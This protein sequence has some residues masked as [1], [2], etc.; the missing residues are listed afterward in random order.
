MGSMHLFLGGVDPEKD[1][2]CHRERIRRHVRGGGFEPLHDLT[3]GAVDGSRMG[4]DFYRRDPAPR[5]AGDRRLSY[6]CPHR[7][8]D[9]LC[10]STAR[11]QCGSDHVPCRAVKWIKNE[12]AHLQYL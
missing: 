11:E 5:D 1:P 8:T 7:G 6:D 2:L 10:I 12:D 9:Y 4:T 3:K